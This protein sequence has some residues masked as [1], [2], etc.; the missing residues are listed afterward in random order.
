MIIHIILYPSPSCCT[1]L[2]IYIV[3]TVMMQP[4]NFKLTPFS[5]V[6]VELDEVDYHDI[7]TFCQKELNDASPGFMTRVENRLGFPLVSVILL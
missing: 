5:K 7:V 6:R 2:I 3:P 1:P 4:S